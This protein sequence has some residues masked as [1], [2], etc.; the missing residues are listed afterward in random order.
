MINSLKQEQKKKVFFKFK[1]LIIMKTQEFD[2]NQ[3]RKN[4]QER[5]ADAHYFYKD[6]SFIRI[7]IR[8]NIHIPFYKTK[9]NCSATVYSMLY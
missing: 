6:S 4:K 7:K 8:H 2:F 9:N 1:N 3:S 5:K